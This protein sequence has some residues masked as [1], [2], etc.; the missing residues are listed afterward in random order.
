VSEFKLAL[1]RAR[2]FHASGATR[3]VAYRGNAL[4]RLEQV[5]DSR[6]PDLLDALN[7][8]LR[9]SAQ[10]AYGSEIGV[11]RTEI[12]YALR[13]LRRWARP[14]RARTPWALAP[15]R[16]R[17]HPEPRGVVLILGPWNFPFNLLFSPLVGAI[18]AGN[19]V[20]L[21][22]SEYAP[23]VSKAMAE[24]VREAFEPGHV[25]LFEGGVEV[26]R[27][28]VE[29]DFDQLFFTG[30]TATG[31]AIMAAAAK[32]LTPVTLELGGKCPC[33]VCP[34]ARLPVAARR[35]AW[36]KF[37]NAGQTCVAPDH[38]IVHRSVRDRFLATLGEVLK[39]YFGDDPR[40]STDFGRIVNRRH[41]D[42]LA[43][44]LAQG[45]I[46][47]G[48]ETDASELYIAP[49]VVLDPEPSAAIMTDEIFGPILPVLDYDDLDEVLAALA[50]RPS[51]LAFYLFSENRATQ[52]HVLAKT[53][54]GGVCINDVVNHIVPKEMPFG[55]IGR[56]GMGQYHGKASFDCFTHYRSVLT[57]STRFDPGYAYPPARFSLK[58]LKRA[59]SALFRD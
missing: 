15:A 39:T 52:D 36:G 22:P 19:C 12:G 37:L 16:G 6:E 9:K 34:D 5:I 28:L 24:V 7:A 32:R 44:Y 8:D 29:L 10:E 3:D 42:R 25:T 58:T 48:G 51:P 27:S 21:K 40:T 13:N 20:F 30:S 35:I 23:A 41:F 47:L 49:T 33:I 59:Y 18:A 31:S 56:S 57:R 14:R 1:R 38:V 50:S 54:S 11:V 2:E 46:V 26:A 45:K 53:V 17:V 43:G 4:G 55:G